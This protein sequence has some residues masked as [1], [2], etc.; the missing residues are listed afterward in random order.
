MAAN[1]AGELKLESSFEL[2]GE[3]LNGRVECHIFSLSYLITRI[4]QNSSSIKWNI[5]RKKNWDRHETRH[6]SAHLFCI[7]YSFFCIHFFCCCR[8][9]MN[10][11]R[12]N[13]NDFKLCSF[14]WIKIVQM[15]W[16]CISKQLSFI[17]H[18]PRL[19]GF[20]LESKLRRL[21]H[22]SDLPQKLGNRW[23]HCYKYFVSSSMCRHRL[24]TNTL[25]YRT[26]HSSGSWVAWKFIW[27]T[28]HNC[29]LFA[30][31]YQSK[32]NVNK[33][34]TR[35]TVRAAQSEMNSDANVLFICF[36]KLRTGVVQ[37]KRWTQIIKSELIVVGVSI[38]HVCINHFCNEIH[39]SLNYW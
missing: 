17:L 2:N 27:I 3:E 26:V 10:Q 14:V 34:A 16:K 25:F 28:H 5:L 13:N 19:A 36:T 1:S 15:R 30:S 35:Y 29:N 9:S 22:K 21:F 4:T 37:L 33:K 18:L 24:F 38:S 6:V 11:L 32:R 31:L 20:S 23:R 8:T 7:L 39:C 12:K